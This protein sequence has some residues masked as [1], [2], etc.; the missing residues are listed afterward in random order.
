MAVEMLLAFALRAPPSGSSLQEALDREPAAVLISSAA[1]LDLQK[2]TGFLPVKYKSQATGF[3]VYQS[4]AKEL[5]SAYPETRDLQ[6]PIQVVVSFE[7]GANPLECASAMHV[8]SVLVGTFGARAFDPQSRSFVGADN[9]QTIARICE[10]GA[11]Q[12]SAS[13]AAPAKSRQ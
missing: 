11:N 7:F 10:D 12:S 1:S 4:T 3:Y 5:Q 9:L 8:A 13:S 6:P 2:H